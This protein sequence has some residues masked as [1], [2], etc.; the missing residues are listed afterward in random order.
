MAYCHVRT[1]SAF[2]VFHT[3]VLGLDLFVGVSIGMIREVTSG[4]STTLSC[5]HGSG[6]DLL[7]SYTGL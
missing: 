1:P 7:M 6:I 2:G 5:C 4:G 3:S